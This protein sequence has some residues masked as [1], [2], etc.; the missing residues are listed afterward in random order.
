MAEEVK[1]SIAD[2]DELRP[3]WRTHV[4]AFVGSVF[5]LPVIENDTGTVDRG[6][7][8]SKH[9]RRFLAR[10]CRLSRS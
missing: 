7:L 9:T 4:L 2:I 6:P 3:N 8:R 5:A 1:C 10:H